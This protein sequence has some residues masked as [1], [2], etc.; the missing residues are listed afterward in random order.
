MGRY[1]LHTSSKA[2][3]CKQQKHN[4]EQNKRKHFRNCEI[5][6]KKLHFVCF[7][8]AKSW[9]SKSLKE[10]L[11][12]HKNTLIVLARALARSNLFPPPSAEGD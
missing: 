1:H 6:L 7:A 5:L 8:K 4:C 3:N 12:V 10:S 9:Q 11:S 2:S